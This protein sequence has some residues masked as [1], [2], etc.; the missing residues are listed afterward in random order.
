MQSQSRAKARDRARREVGDLD[1]AKLDMLGRR[2]RREGGRDLASREPGSR[3]LL[4]RAIPSE[5]GAPDVGSRNPPLTDAALRGRL[6]TML[7][8]RAISR[9]PARA[10]PKEPAA[11][12]DAGADTAAEPAADPDRGQAA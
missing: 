6:N 1:L 8:S 5:L 7:G 10:A 3:D 9:P 4:A 12:D 11:T 2:R